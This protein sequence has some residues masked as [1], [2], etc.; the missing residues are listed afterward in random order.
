MQTGQTACV[1]VAN[2]A[3]D[4]ISRKEYIAIS[5]KFRK[6]LKKYY[7]CEYF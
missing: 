2:M 4:I 1:G 3:K 7:N 5:I 6:I